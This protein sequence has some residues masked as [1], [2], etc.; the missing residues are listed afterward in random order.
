MPET[1]SRIVG[2]GFTTI[3][4]MGQPI[5][6]CDAFADTGQTLVGAGFEAVHP[7]GDRHPREIAVARA[8]SAGTLSITVR[9]LWN[10]PVWWQLAGMSGTLDL[11]SVYEAMASMPSA[12]TAQ[13]LIKPPGQSTWRGKNYHGLVITS[14]P[15]D[16][17]VTLGALTFPRVITAMYTHTTPVNVPAGAA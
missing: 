9:E 4:W 11:I 3:N 2:S 1:K 15:D 8:V 16:E 14:I 12:M 7:I 17:T 13:M 6:W 10:E 5:I